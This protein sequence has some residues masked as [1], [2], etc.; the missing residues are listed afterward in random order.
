VHTKPSRSTLTS[1]QISTAHV[2][3]DQ[4][5]PH[6]VSALPVSNKSYMEDV[7][8]VLHRGEAVFGALPAYLDCLITELHLHPPVAIT[9]LCSRTISN[10][11][12]WL[13]EIE[14]LH[15]SFGAFAI[16]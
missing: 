16:P 3:N 2:K 10:V 7:L 11:V 9:R 15:T 1:H 8:S 14:G 12:D 13:F 6:Q 5:Q 4:M